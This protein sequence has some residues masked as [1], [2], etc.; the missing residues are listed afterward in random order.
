MSITTYSELQTAM[1]SWL[2]NSVNSASYAD[3]ITVFESAANRRLRA[4]Q[5]ET[6][7]T[8][9]TSS[10]V[11]TLPTDYLHWR[12]ATLLA[13]T[14]VELE[15]VAPD[16][17]NAAYPTQP[18][19]VSRV[20]TIEGSSLKVMPI[21]DSGVELVYYAKIPS[22]SASVTSNWLLTAHPDVYLFGALSEAEMFGVNDQ[23]AALWA[24]RR[25][26]VFDEIQSLSNKSRGQGGQ[27]VL[28]IT[29]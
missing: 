19:D 6:T 23:R 28:A 20:F 11:G 24:Q 22:L 21:D 14:R 1:T 13:S 15:Y 7:T 4:R 29:P 25:D 27:R 8:V 5:Q 17:F 18:S 10:G 16:Y 12:R 9:T 26:N 3:M 2:G